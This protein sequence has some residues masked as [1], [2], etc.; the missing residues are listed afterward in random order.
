VVGRPL[1]AVVALK[2]PARV[3]DLL[4]LQPG[5][6]DEP[7]QGIV[8]F[9][10]LAAGLALD[11]RLDVHLAGH[12][13]ELVEIEEPGNAFLQVL[14]EEVARRAL[15]RDFLHQ[16]GKFPGGIAFRDLLER[17]A[18]GLGFPLRG[19][20]PSP[21]HE[22]LNEGVFTD[23]QLRDQRVLIPFGKDQF[24]FCQDSGEILL[25]PS[26]FFLIEGESGPCDNGRLP[27][28]AFDLDPVVF[29]VASG[30]V[31]VDIEGTVLGDYRVEPGDGLQ[32][33][34]LTRLVHS[35]EARYI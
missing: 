26:Q 14:F 20:N 24:G 15:P 23:A 28:S 34:G 5:K 33:G 7:Q 29:H 9:Q 30:K 18:L 17:H 32:N 6:I 31:V 21:L 3:D 22:G 27:P 11:E 4:Q 2:G 13:V 10:Q 25:Q 16:G 19:V 1:Q 8:G 35:D 12:L